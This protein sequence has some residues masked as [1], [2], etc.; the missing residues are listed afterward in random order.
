MVNVLYCVNGDVRGRSWLRHSIDSLLRSHRESRIF[1]ASD[2]PFS[3]GG[4]FW[5]DAVP[6]IE[7]FGMRRIQS[8]SKMGMHPSPMQIFR[9][10]APCLDE[11]KSVDAILYMDIDTEVVRPGIDMLPAGGFGADVMALFEHSKH[12]DK[13]TSIM[14]A[15]QELR[16]E[17]SDH[18]VRRLK[19]GGYF[20]SGV[21]L[22]DLSHMRKNHPGW[23]KEL[24]HVIDMAVRHHRV[25]V[26]QDISNVVLDAVPIAPEFNVMPDTDVQYNVKNPCVVHYADM[27]K[28]RSSVYPPPNVRA[29][30]TKSLGT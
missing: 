5:I 15:D 24:P 17:M 29:K 4:A 9:L 20:N 25:V 7:R 6:Y 14:L 30:L 11:L 2:S 12:G 27:S 28:Y 23:D 10:A 1:V 18:T 21:M 16:S 8:V 26:D 3:Y 22:M 19:G 13:S